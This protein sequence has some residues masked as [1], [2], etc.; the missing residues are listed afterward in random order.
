MDTTEY[1]R[2]SAIVQSSEDAII[3]NLLD[4]TTTSWN[5]AAEHIFGFTADEAI[6]KNISIIIPADLVDEE[7]GIISRVM[8]GERIDHYETTR[9]KKS[10]EPVAIALTISPIKDAG[11]TIIGI[12]KIARDIRAQRIAE[13]KQ[14]ILAAIIDSSDDAI[15]SKNLDGVITSWNQGAEKIFGYKEH[16]AVGK[17]I[18]LIIP[19]ALIG[20]EAHIISQIRSGKRISHFETVRL[21]KDGREINISL[22]VSPVKNKI[23]NV[24][25]ASKIARDITEKFELEQQQKLLTERLQ[26]LNYYKDEFMAMASHELKTPLTVIK[27][28]LQVLE[29]MVQH[30]SN[31][32]FVSKSL[33][34]VNKL[35]DLITDLLDVSKI[36]TGKLELNQTAF[37]LQPFLTEIIDSIQQASPSHTIT[38]T[39]ENPNIIAKGD[40]DRLEQVVIN[41]LTNAVK[42]SPNAEAVAVNAGIRDGMILVE[43]RD[44]GIG[45][46]PDDVDKV[47]TRFFRVR[48]LAST[49]SGSGIGLYISSEIIKRH[50]GNIWVESEAGK[51]SVFYFTIP[52]AD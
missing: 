28:N 23:G 40:R 5:P 16:E 47:F 4:G 42:Y 7:R 31:M 14:A 45:I 11:G 51:G 2:L 41:I 35:S 50:G 34:Q 20:E 30:D 21:T 36:Q 29:Q 43:V 32:D 38:L 49:F 17:H 22:T 3:S 24:I 8:T 15:V 10:G 39:T 26:E 25:G 27:A 18:S 6:G 13:E 44:S 52:L 12:S 37:A 1:V 19:V 33:R 9:K 46:P 48:G